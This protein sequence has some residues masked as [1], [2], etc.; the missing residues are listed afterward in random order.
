MVHVAGIIS[1]GVFVGKLVDKHGRKWSFIGTCYLLSIFS[2]LTV[3][4]SSFWWFVFYRFM[5]G[6]FTGVS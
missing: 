1:G 3:V 2:V 4:P 5:V 6:V